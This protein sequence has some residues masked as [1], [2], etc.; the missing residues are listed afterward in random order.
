MNLNRA[1]SSIG[2]KLAFHLRKIETIF[3]ILERYIII[4][5]ILLILT[6]SFGSIILR[7]VGFS[8]PPWVSSILQQ[9]VLWVAFLGGALAS[10]YNRQVNFNIL[11]HIFEKRAYINRILIILINLSIVPVAVLFCI[12]VFNYVR[13]EREWGIDIPSLGIKSWYFATILIYVFAMIAFRYFV[14]FLEAAKGIPFPEEKEEAKSGG[15][16]I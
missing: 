4:A 3:S 15:E 2:Y 5:I 6:L 8:I 1:D 14:R 13:F 16:E 7:N 11:F 9:A 12:G 10:R